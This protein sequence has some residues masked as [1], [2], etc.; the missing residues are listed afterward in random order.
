MLQVV[1]DPYYNFYAYALTSRHVPTLMGRRRI[2]AL[3]TLPTITR[4]QRSEATP[5]ICVGFEVFWG[6]TQTTP[7]KVR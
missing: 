3:P 2:D 6:L 4:P 1:L 7:V 5:A